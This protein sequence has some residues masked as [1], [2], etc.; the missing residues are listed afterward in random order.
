MLK[1]SAKVDTLSSCSRI[2]GILMSVSR[3]TTMTVL[4]LIA[5]FIPFE[6][7]TSALLVMDVALFS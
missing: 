3:N 7:L 4:R 6:I 5:S 2:V 1:T